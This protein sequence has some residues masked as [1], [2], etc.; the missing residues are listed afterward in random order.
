MTDALGHKALLLAGN[1]YNVIP[2][3]CARVCVLSV[4]ATRVLHIQA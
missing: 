1:A 2:P 3:G 4:I